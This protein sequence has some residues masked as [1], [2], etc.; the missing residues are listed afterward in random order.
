MSSSTVRSDLSK[1]R[2]EIRKIDPKI[3][4]LD[5]LTLVNVLLFGLGYLYV[6]IFDVVMISS[7]GALLISPLIVAG[8]IHIFRHSLMDP[9]DDHNKSRNHYFN[10]ILIAL[11]LIALGFIYGIVMSFVIR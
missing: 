8:A 7:N 3:K 1:L 10:T 6:S 4:F 2:N 9:E 5:L 11:G